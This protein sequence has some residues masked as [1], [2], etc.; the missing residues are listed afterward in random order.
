MV[1]KIQLKVKRL[2]HCRELP[3]Y[4]TPGSSGM[5]LTAALAQPLRLEPGMRASI[6][7]GIAVEIPPGFEGQLRPRSG[8]AAKAGITLTNSVGT[9]DSD[10]RGEVKVLLI[11]HG[12]DPYTF[13]PGERIAQL[14]IMP[15]PQVEL[16]EVGE[17]N[18]QNVRGEGGFGSTGRLAIGAAGQ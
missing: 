5:D 10:Y 12:Q 4:A 2:P 11:N 18:S 15:V 14:V 7:T 1:E 8:L 17:L 3:K 13:E 6:P 16:V 9:I